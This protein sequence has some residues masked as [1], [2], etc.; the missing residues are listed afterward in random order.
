[1]DSKCIYNNLCNSRK[2][3]KENWKPGSGLHRHH[4]I[5]KHSGGSDDDSNLTYLTVREHII[6]HYLLWRIHKNVN[7]LR[8]MKMLGAK[9]STDQRRK[10][11]IFCK[12][13]KIGFH[14][15][16]QEQ[17]R[18][19][20][21]KGLESQKKSQ[22]KNSFYY[23][24]TEEGREK[25]SSL[26]GKAGSKSQMEHKIGIHTDDQHKRTEW[27]SLGGASHKGKKA[28]FK[29]GDNTFKRVPPNKFEEYL[30]EGY[31]FGSP[32]LP[33]NKGSKKSWIYHNDYKTTKQ[34]LKSELHAYLHKGWKKGRKS[35]NH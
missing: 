32:F 4:I 17:I 21:L 30:N 34:I 6:A 35:F 3:L 10:I 8:S 1:M 16:S 22:S 2:V 27:A 19:W 28:M 29:P 33:P 9:L 15:A 18:E 24:S 23:W 25:R 20:R 5:P 12:E 11:G 26:G 31:V 13:N 14:G 7:D